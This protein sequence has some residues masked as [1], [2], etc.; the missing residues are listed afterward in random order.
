MTWQL[1]SFVSAVFLTREQKELFI[2]H[3]VRGAQK[4]LFNFH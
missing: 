1:V 3:R 2:S 4:N